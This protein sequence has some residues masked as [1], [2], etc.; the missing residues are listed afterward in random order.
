MLVYRNF[1]MLST[2]G[3]TSLIRWGALDPYQPTESVVA[4]SVADPVGAAHF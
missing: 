3:T 1:Y 4:F 2:V